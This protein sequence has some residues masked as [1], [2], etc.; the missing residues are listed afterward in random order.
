MYPSIPHLN[1]RQ[2]G[3]TM[4]DADWLKI[5]QLI[6][7]VKSGA[8]KKLESQFGSEKV[9]VYSCGPNVVRVDIKQ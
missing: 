9:T 3:E 1:P 7:Q 6:D 2:G 4:T 5:R 8:V